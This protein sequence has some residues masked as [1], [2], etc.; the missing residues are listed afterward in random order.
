MRYLAVLVP[1]LASGCI[2]NMGWGEPRVWV[3]GER[4]F[5]VDPA[6]LAQVSC[7]T[8]NGNVT[9]AGS[10]AG[11]KILVR[12]KTRAGGDDD[13]DAAA[14]HEAIEILHKRV[15]GGLSLGW[16]WR[17]PYRRTWR[18]SVSFDITQPQTMPSKI[19]TH[20]G[21]VR[22]SGITAAVA[23]ESHNGDLTLLQ[24][25]GDLRGVT[26]N[27]DIEAATSGQEV[28]LVSHNGRLQV[29]IAGSGPVHGEIR[30]HNGGIR[31]GVDGGRSARL[32]CNTQNG[33]VSCDRT[34]ERV[35]RGRR[36]LV[37]DLGSGEGRLAVET[38]N[39]SIRIE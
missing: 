6:D 39:G 37:A 7:S 25:A 27:G 36:F 8:H 17:E 24:C 28:S 5:E 32:V 31:L 22:V 33:R 20:N 4:A 10:E 15:D 30:S 11:G 16:R 13:Q 9:V 23:A 26:H 29:Q 1:L 35:E 38:Y 12:V 34:L 21:E 3:S 2:I 18:A 19:E 14:A